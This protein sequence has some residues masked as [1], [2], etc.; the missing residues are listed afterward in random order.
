M[1][2]TSINKHEQNVI[3]TRIT[4][5]D[6]GRTFHNVA[7]FSCRQNRSHPEYPG[8][9][10]LQKMSPLPSFQEY[11]ILQKR[12]NNWGKSKT[13]QASKSQS[14]IPVTHLLCIAC[15][16]PCDQL[17][18]ALFIKLNDVIEHRAL[19][20]THKCDQSL[21]SIRPRFFVRDRNE[22][23]FYTHWVCVTSLL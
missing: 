18:K 2:A 16:L 14:T 13:E 19:P 4:T 9:S 12:N 7:S 11:G 5:I 8:L 22:T 20:H 3:T 6:R 23:L 17:T 15:F 10:E 1:L 21:R